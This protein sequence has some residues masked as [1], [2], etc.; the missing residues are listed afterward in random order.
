[1]N[2]CA[3][4]IDKDALLVR[5]MKSSDL[6]QVVLIERHAQLSPWARLSFEESLTKEHICR[7][8]EMSNDVVAYFVVCPVA[9]ELHILN[10]VTAPSCQGVGLGHLLMD[11]I[12]NCA[13]NL[14]LRKI[15]LEV[16]AS[17]Y[18]AQ[19][20]YLKWQFEQIAIRKRYYSMPNTKNTN[21][22]EDALVYL[23][24]LPR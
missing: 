9:D 14:S 7:V 24:Q 8:I 2:I 4:M 23:R 20:L 19:S 12:L 1:M 5:D 22:R 21:D 16:R 15:F 18:V 10:V 6:S 13:Q 17:N 3:N 11:N